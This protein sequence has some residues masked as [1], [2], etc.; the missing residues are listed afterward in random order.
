[1]D[2]WAVDFGF[3]DR[4]GALIA[5]PVHYR[6]KKRNAVTEEVFDRIPAEEL[7]RLTGA[8]VIPVMSLFHMFSLV[9][10][11]SFEI[12]NAHKFLMI[13][14]LFHYFLSGEVA[15]D[16]TNVTS[17]LMYNQMRRCWEEKILSML[18]VCSD[19]FPRLLEPG[20]VI[21]R[22]QKSVAWDL[23]LPEIPVVNPATW[24]SASALTGIPVQ[25]M[26]ADWVYLSLGTWAVLGTENDQLVISAEAFK[27]GFSNIGQ[28]EGKNSLC[29]DTTGLWIIQQCR[30]KWMNDQDRSINWEEV[31]DAANSVPSLRCF[32]DVE[33]PIFSDMQP[34]MPET[35]RLYCIQT[36]QIVPKD[37][38]AVA[39][40]VYDSLIMKLREYVLD[41]QSI[42]GQKS[43]VLYMT[44]GGT[45]S[46]ILCQW[47][48]D[49]TEMQ[50]LAVEEE[51]TAIG[52]FLMQLKATGEIQNTEEGRALAARSVRVSKYDPNKEHI[53]IWRDAWSIYQKVIGL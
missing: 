15:N 12:N 30:E 42:T 43:E 8:S 45:K 37:L 10:K 11:K 49:A 2:T 20:T 28:P 6:D 17:T 44:G 1:V 4:Q 40:C 32:I 21:G 26:A 36:E 52:N 50:V 16:F 31:L 29:R 23:Q 19:I 33:D 14:D 13:P 48:A 24:D 53:P 3:I 25:H 27:K 46:S 5:N 38:G 47:I 41:L 34:N 39:R 7:F 35:V 22:I 51:T 18:G 9:K